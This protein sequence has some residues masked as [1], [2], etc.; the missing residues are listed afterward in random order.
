MSSSF[1]LK[2]FLGLIPTAQKIDSAW[3]ELIRMKNELNQ[4]E[5]SKELARY[6]ELNQ[7]IQSVHFQTKRREIINL[8]L[9]ASS[10]NAVLTELAKL[11][12]SKPIKNYFKFLKSSDF[13][14]INKIAESSEL[15]SYLE[16]KKI[17]GSPDFIRRKKEIESLRFKD[18]PEYIKKQNYIALAK[19]SRLKRYQSTLASDEYRLFLEL[20][21]SEKEKL[22]DP[23]RKKDPK[24]KIYQKFLNSGAY[25]NLRAVEKH[26]LQAQFEKLKQE[27]N[28]QPFLEREAFLKN[29][30]RYETTPDYPLYS[31]FMRLSKNID[32]QFYLKGIISAPYINFQ[33]IAESTE[34]ARLELLRSQVEEPGFK[35]QVAFLK[36]KKRY[37]STEEY[38]LEKEFS[39]LEKSKI[40][41]T[42]HQLKK[43]S[44]L[45]FFDQWEVVL[46]ENFTEQQLAATLWEPENYWGSKMAGCSFS[47]ANELQ[48]YKG[49]K[50]IEIRNTVLSI[51]TKAEK[52]EGKVWDPIVGLIPRKFDYSSAILNTGNYFKFKE[53]VIEAKVKFRA[54][55]AITSAFSL[56]GIKPF[57]QI[58]VFRSGN[59]SVG[60][61]IIDQPG[62][63]TIKK[64]VQI[65]GL[66]FNKFHIFRLEVSGNEA[67]WK[68]NNHEVHRAQLPGNLGELFINFIG[69]LHQ[70]LNGTSLP[71][72][73]EIDWVRCWSKK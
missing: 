59:N 9:S 73:F 20:E 49:L 68:I 36:N 47:Q 65:K 15:L 34:L 42:Y 30:A 63:G 4:I 29:R 35:Q 52:S 11:E 16:L 19:N 56:T 66:N 8:S 12:Q 64:L 18:S 2:Y 54:E 51:V 5:T 32:L 55:K 33:S 53:G 25:Q 1:R 22:K 14:R 44:E 38:K 46:D 72:H 60:L 13:V 23:A 31:E 50:N 67:V 58:D 3:T 61:G 10:E 45:A 69:S 48:A 26:G 70:P 24:E 41:T 62:K 57:P 40:I 28:T 7:L 37:E 17:V 39:E 27:I 43:R 71:H 6:E 21:V